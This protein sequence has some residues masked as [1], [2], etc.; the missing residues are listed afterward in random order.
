[1]KTEAKR[2][3]A[4]FS[5]APG[6]TDSDKLNLAG[7]LVKIGDPDTAQVVLERLV[8]S[9]PKSAEAQAKLGLL[10][11]DKN[12]LKQAAIHLRNAVQLAPESPE[13]ALSFAGVLILWKHPEAAVKFLESVENSFGTLP[14]FRYKLGL[15]YYSFN[16]Y[17]RAIEELKKLERQRPDSD[18]VQLFL[19]LSYVASGQLIEAEAHFRKAVELDPHKASNYIPLAQLLRKEGGEKTDEAI[20]NLQALLGQDPSN[21]QCKLELALCYEKRE[22]LE[23]SQ[24]LLE[25]VTRK[26][27]DLVEAHVALARVYRRLGKTQEADRERTAL[28]KLEDRRRRSEESLIPQA[29]PSA[30][31]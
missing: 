4:Q 27:P 11:S 17:P 1:M 10:L 18:L 24:V 6:A 25:E 13:Y 8:Q 28:R 15:A 22:R 19:G 26:Q 5:E 7:I 21:L 9:S 23:D 14:E 12:Q 29:L 30:N 2:E 3:A 31:Q 20:R 16:Q